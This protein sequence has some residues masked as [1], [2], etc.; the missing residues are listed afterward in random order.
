MD[1]GS[2]RLGEL[3]MGIKL[4]QEAPDAG[5]APAATYPLLTGGI[6]HAVG[7]EAILL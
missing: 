4:F 5:D 2:D 7:L 6:M 1:E 3:P